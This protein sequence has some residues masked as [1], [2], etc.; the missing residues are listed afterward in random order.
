[1]PSG[2]RP[3]THH[4]STQGRTRASSQPKVVRHKPLGARPSRLVFFFRQAK[5]YGVQGV[6]PEPADPPNPKMIRT[7][8]P[9]PANT[10]PPATTTLTNSVYLERVGKT[11]VRGN[12]T[13]F[14]SFENEQKICRLIRLPIGEMFFRV[15]RFFAPIAGDL[16]C[17]LV[18]YE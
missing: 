17:K 2:L 10:K 6:R 14:F 3:L 15:A 18:K 7:T 9:P 1:M 11:K 12:F 16:H 4:G 5:C 8:T 13:V